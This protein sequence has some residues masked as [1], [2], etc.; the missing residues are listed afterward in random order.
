MWTTHLHAILD[1]L[2]SKP[3]VEAE[4]RAVSRCCA[5]CIPAAE[6]KGAG[7]GPTATAAAAAQLGRSITL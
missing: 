3:T 4:L 5:A 2:F 6:R 7:V 1:A